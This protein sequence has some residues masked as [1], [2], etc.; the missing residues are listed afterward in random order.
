MT[1]K[2]E[3]CQEIAELQRQIAQLKQAANDVQSEIEYYAQIFKGYQDY[4]DGLTKNNTTR[5]FR[6][7]LREFIVEVLG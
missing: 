7:T 4:H 1:T 6:A 2:H 3:L 5:L